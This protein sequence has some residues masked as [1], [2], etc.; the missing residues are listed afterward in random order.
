M[1]T[2]EV[3]LW[4]CDD[5][6]VQTPR[7]LE[8]YEGWL[9][10]AE[11][12]RRARF[13]FAA[14]R[15]Q[16]LVSRALLRWVLGRYTGLDPASLRFGCNAWGK[17]HLELA[18]SGAP[19]FNLSHTDGLIVLAVAEVNGQAA[20][21]ML[22]VDVERRDRVV[23]APALAMRFFSA[24]ESDTLHGLPGEHQRSCFFDFW[25]LKEAYIKAVGMGL[26]IP[27]ADF[28]FSLLR[29][30]DIDIRFTASRSADD[31]AAWQFRRLFHQAGRPAADP[32]E[33]RDEGDDGDEGKERNKEGAVY[34][35]ALALRGGRAL[36]ITA[37][38][39]APLAGFEITGLREPSAS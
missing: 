18:D 7:L 28:S 39:G 25:T 33:E 20:P 29:D 31:P 17:P 27:L 12:A 23:N 5:R 11:R 8:T 15:H 36:R 22:G 38:I 26:G 14:H 13:R 35:L 10:D 32:E 2:T 30:G 34:Q 37:R 4:L 1:Q 16:F 3:T 21:P 24:L 9:S 6:A 19:E